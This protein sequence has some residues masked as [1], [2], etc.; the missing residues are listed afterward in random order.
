MDPFRTLPTE[1]RVDILVLL[2]DPQDLTCIT[3]AINASPS[4]LATYIVNKN[5]IRRRFYEDELSKR[6]MQHALGVILF[7]PREPDAPPISSALKRHVELWQ[8]QRLTFPDEQ[9]HSTTLESFDSLYHRI[10]QCTQAYL[11]D[12]EKWDGDPSRL[13]NR[14]S[15]GVH[16]WDQLKEIL[17]NYTNS[18]E[19]YSEVDEFI[20]RGNLIT[21]CFYSP[22]FVKELRESLGELREGFRELEE[23]IRKLREDISS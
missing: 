9:N 15:Y 1:N 23:G 11:T 10:R 20:H 18:D 8:C 16:M 21:R 3:S 13:S 7:P 2:Q 19:E 22:E 14:R 17:K 6:L 5:S 12:Y 4:M